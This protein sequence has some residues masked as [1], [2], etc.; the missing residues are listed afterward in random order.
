M[1]DTKKLH[2]VLFPWLA[3]G[4]LIPFFELAK[5]IERKGHNVSYVSTSRNI[6]RL[7][8][9]SQKLNYSI[10]FVNLSLPLT[11]DLPEN[12]EATKDVPLDKVQYLKKA[13]DGLES[14]LTQ[15]LEDSVPDW[16][17]YDFTPYWLPSIAGRLGISRAFFSTFNAWSSL[18]FGPAK[19]VIDGNIQRTKPEDFTV[20]PKWIPFPSNIAFRLYEINRFFGHGQENVSGVS[21]W[22]RFGKSVSGCDVFLVRSSNELEREWLDLLPELHQKPIVPVGLLPPSVQNT[23]GDKSDA[24]GFINNWLAMQREKSVV[25]VALGTEATP[26]Q[27]ELT[28]LAHGLE[29]S[30]L[31]FFWALRKQHDYLLLKLPEGFEERTNNRGIVWTNWAPQLRIL[32]HD[33]VG[34]FLTHC[35]WGSIIEGLQFGKPLVMLPFLGDQALN[36]RGLEE[37]MVG[38]EIPRNETDG[39]LTRNSVAESLKLV[40]NDEKGKIYWEKANEMR[41]IFGNRDLCDNYIDDLIEYLHKNRS[42]CMD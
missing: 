24:W 37:K 15:F 33:S 23:E 21:D 20:P 2:V 29:L 12:A 26:S 19:D 18:F 7:P 32:E 1:A 4:H 42:I 38:L 3:F 22:H 8:K 13:F 5:Q 41:K 17:I 16:I 9:L 10:H 6:N 14:E 25:Y 34:G 27:E 31:P 30:G 40:M 28:E 36:A 11:K 39:S 35:G